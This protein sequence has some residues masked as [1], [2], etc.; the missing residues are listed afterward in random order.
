MLFH[1]TDTGDED[2][3]TSEESNIRQLGQNG[4]TQ[5]GIIPY[6][7]KYCE[8]TNEKLTDVMNESVN[9]VFYIVSYEI[10]KAQE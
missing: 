7:L 5:F 3:E 10:I 9:F 6:L 4:I 2:T 8:V 1:S